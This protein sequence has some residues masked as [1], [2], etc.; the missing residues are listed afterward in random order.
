MA[1][2]KKVTVLKIWRIVMNLWQICKLTKVL[3]GQKW[4]IHS[5]FVKSQF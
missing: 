4:G 5:N 3:F 2:N 1:L